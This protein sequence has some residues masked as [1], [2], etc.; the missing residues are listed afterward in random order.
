MWCERCITSLYL[1]SF[2]GKTATGRGQG[3]KST[4]FNS[5]KKKA[6]GQLL[7]RPRKPWHGVSITS[8]SSQL[9]STGSTAAIATGPSLASCRNSRH[10]CCRSECLDCEYSVSRC[11]TG[12]DTSLAAFHKNKWRQW[13]K[14]EGE[15]IL[16]TRV[17]S[18]TFLQQCSSI[19]D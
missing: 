4:F 2:Q 9:A 8:T 15:N 16:E 12:G 7:L 18:F 1:P 13:R 5:F 10:L 17:S 19:W 11:A 3:L 6:G 14:G